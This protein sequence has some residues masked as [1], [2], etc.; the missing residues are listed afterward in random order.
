MSKNMMSCLWYDGR[1]EE[2]AN[3]YVDTFKAAGRQAAITDELRWG[4]VG[5]G[6]AG[7]ILTISFE[8]EGR[9]FVALNGGP[10]FTFTPAVSF[11]VSCSTQ[12]EIDYFWEK[13]QEGGGRP[14]Q[15]G[16]L[17][18]RFG[19]SWQVVAAPLYDFLKSSD[20]AASGRAMAAMMEMTKLDI[21]KLQAA[22][23]N[24]A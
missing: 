7:S 14:S 11:M 9:P 19:L 5:P 20:K 6:P 10:H 1:A 18:D 23:D 8:L 12:K 22:Y 24:A 16:W 13:L 3:F 17:N 4:E 2:A 15:C 21:A